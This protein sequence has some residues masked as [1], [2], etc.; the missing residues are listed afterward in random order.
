MP[1]ENATRISELDPA[2]PLGS[3]SLGQGDDHIRM[4]KQVLQNEETGK[5]K[6]F[7]SL[8][9]AI[10][11]E[12][13]V[14][15]MAADL[16]E[17]TTGNGDGATWDYVDITTVTI[18]GIDIVACTGVPTLAL[19][20]RSGYETL[21]TLGAIAN[22][23]ASAILTRL[24]EIKT[25]AIIGEFTTP[26]LITGVTIPQ[27]KQL[28]LGKLKTT[29]DAKMLSLS[30]DS[31]IINVELFGDGK[32]SGKTLQDLVDMPVGAIG[33]KMT[34]VKL[35][36][37]G[38]SGFKPAATVTSEFLG[39]VLNS[40]DAL[41]CNIGLNLAERGEYINVIGS[42]VNG[43]NQGVIH[44]GGNVNVNGAIV[45]NNVE[46]YRLAAGVNDAHGVTQGCQI[47][48]NT[49]NLF[50]EELQAKNHSFI[51]NNIFAGIIHLQRCEGVQFMGGSWGVVTIREEGCFNCFVKDVY[52]TD[53]IASEPNYNGETSE[54]LYYGQMLNK[55]TNI[56]LA[57]EYIQ[58][59][60]CFSRL[61]SNVTGIATTTK[62]VVLLN[63][64]TQ[65][66]AYNPT[67]TKQ[68]LYNVS[69][70]EL[71][72]KILNLKGGRWVNINAS[73][74]V[75]RTDAID[76]DPEL[77]RVY[78]RNKSTGA[79]NAQFRAGIQYASGSVR[80]RNY[81]IDVTVIKENYEI[82]IE[83]NTGVSLTMYLDLPT[84]TGFQQLSRLTVKEC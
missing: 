67:Y 26:P 68:S 63:Q 74:T 14:E 33:I 45:T 17:R 18:N 32:A 9:S 72:L 83:N 81:E 73:I 80:L 25:V 21:K 24:L 47:N 4:M 30:R 48:H 27:G 15:G 66:T 75:G 22:T 69:T 3:D 38:G 36:D 76:L 54:L 53:Q 58:G 57:N 59:V 37:A 62:H 5:V 28:A 1:L 12:G 35:R 23:D 13:A 82:V 16:K 50:I 64:S 65:S 46:G 8:A 41:D 49:T 2:N 20:I 56:A 71:A 78:L 34:N 43:C 61:T 60:Y 29:T 55:G 52:L 44:Q 51:G 10:A 84:N 40:V 39:G 77:A 79:I 70:G 42:Q 7:L 19:V 31:S 11:F 6:H